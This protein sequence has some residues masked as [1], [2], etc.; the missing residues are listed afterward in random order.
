MA[1]PEVGSFHLWEPVCQH[2]CDSLNMASASVITRSVLCDNV[3][4]I[5]YVHC[6]DDVSD[7]IPMISCP[8]IALKA[9]VAHI[10]S[11]QNM[12]KRH[13]LYI[14]DSALPNLTN[15][16]GPLLISISSSSVM[17]VSYI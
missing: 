10:S 8:S 11:L 15:V 16:Q 17:K 6:I 13:I 14:L 12:T 2:Q 1:K 7:E 4:D 5:M 9:R 3:P